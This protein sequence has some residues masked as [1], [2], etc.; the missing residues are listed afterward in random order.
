[1]RK[2]WLVF[3]YEYRYHV[4]RWRF[5]GTLLALPL[6]LL[7]MLALFVVI[8]WTSFDRSP[9]GIVDQA[10]FFDPSLPLTITN[11]RVPLLKT[12]FQRYASESAARAALDANQ[13]KVFYVFPPDFRQNRQ[14]DAFYTQKPEPSVGG[15][16]GSLVLNQ[17]LRAYPTGRTNL[18]SD[19]S[20]IVARS[21]SANPAEGKGAERSESSLAI[22]RIL[23]PY[24]SVFFMFSAL[25]TSVGYLSR[26]MADEKANRTIE[27]LV[28]SVSPEQLMVG[29]ITALVSVG[30]TQICFWFSWL[31]VLAAVALISGLRIEQFYPGG[32]GLLAVLLAMALPTLLLFS[33][34][35]V[36]ITVSLADPREGQQFAMLV[37]FINM[38][39]FILTN[40][41]MVHPNGTLALVL[42]FLPFTT[43]TTLMLRAAFTTLPAWQ[44]AV[45]WVSLLAGTGVSFWLTA[46]VFRSSML[47]YGASIFGKTTISGL[48]KRARSY[49]CQGL[50]Q[51]K[52][53]SLAEGD[54][55]IW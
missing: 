36:M 34:L 7:I 23:I 35:V 26:A 33:A 39:P 19:G 18:L 45:G 48:F 6:Y 16:V 54:R 32:A 42:S 41:I 12:Q 21:V 17:Y 50:R 37:N 22:S 55:Q 3:W 8:L 44:I 49:R 14:I 24:L 15:M 11:A 31:P 53:H 13:I 5:L 1:M 2:F 51:A 38:A 10:G 52:R 46:K 43:G 30:L 40:V 29:K 4:F 20:T 9:V 27:I 28:T 47:R 25:S